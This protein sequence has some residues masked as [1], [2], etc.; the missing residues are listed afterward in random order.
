M[1]HR[2][3]RNLARVA[4]ILPEREKRGQVI[5]FPSKSGPTRP[6]AE[7]SPAYYV[8]REPQTACEHGIGRAEAGRVELASAPRPGVSS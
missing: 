4:P 7:F 6:P 8:T 1:R 5:E 2:T 3:H